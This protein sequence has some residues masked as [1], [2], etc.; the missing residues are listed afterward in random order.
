MTDYN[1]YIKNWGTVS[2][3]I[4]EWSQTKIDAMYRTAA[5][6]QWNRALGIPIVIAHTVLNTI[7]V[8]GFLAEPFMTF[9]KG[10]NNIRK[11][12]VLLGTG[13][14]IAALGQS[15]SV[16]VSAAYFV[17]ASAIRLIAL[18][19]FMFIAPKWTCEKTLESGNKGTWNEVFRHGLGSLELIIEDTTGAMSLVK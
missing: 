1:D 11:C 6:S 16:V 8:A 9:G 2:K 5:K 7:E 12:H 4:T 18:P 10:L 17:V 13:Q 19:I 3:P 15:V 14:L